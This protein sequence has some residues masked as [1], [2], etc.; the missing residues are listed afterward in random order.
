MVTRPTYVMCLRWKGISTPN[1]QPNP[2]KINLK[3]MHKNKCQ[4][5]KIARA[6]RVY[7]NKWRKKT[8][9]KNHLKQQKNQKSKKRNKII[10]RRKKRVAWA[11]NLKI[12][13]LKCPKQLQ[14]LKIPLSPKEN[15][16]KTQKPRARKIK[17]VF[18]KGKTK[19]MFVMANKR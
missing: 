10:N 1:C 13:N 5:Q 18:V 3:I 11:Q 19:I 17:E 6:S 4:S 9:L 8:N 16:N 2:R 14:T 7:L 12:L 15:K